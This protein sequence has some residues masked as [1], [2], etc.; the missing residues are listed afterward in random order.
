MNRQVPSQ[1]YMD[2]EQQI[3][4]REKVI[5]VWMTLHFFKLLMHGSY[6]DEP[7]E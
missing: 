7:G 6:F 5:T 3:L 2:G 4:Q 1:R